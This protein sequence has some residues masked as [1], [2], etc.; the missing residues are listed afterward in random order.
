VPA[1]SILAN[2]GCL[3]Q[4]LSASEAVTTVWDN[5]TVPAFPVAKD[6]KMCC[7]TFLHS[8][9]HLSIS[10]DLLGDEKHGPKKGPPVANHWM[11]SFC[12]FDREK[13]CHT[14]NLPISL[15]SMNH[16]ESC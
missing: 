11:V 9:I 8:F 15:L 6:E 13:V 2:L 14:A 12:N 7:Q 10:L 3:S 16:D 1:A 5:A 4:C